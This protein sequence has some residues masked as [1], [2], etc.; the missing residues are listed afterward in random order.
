MHSFYKSNEC[1]PGFYTFRKSRYAA[2]HLSR[3]EPD[4][5]AQLAAVQATKRHP[6]AA[7]HAGRR[8]ATRVEV[9]GRS[10]DSP[11]HTA[12]RTTLASGQVR[13]AKS[14]V[15]T[16]SHQGLALSLGSGGRSG[17]AT[18]PNGTGPGGVGRSDGSKHPSQAATTSQGHGCASALEEFRVEGLLHPHKKHLKG[19]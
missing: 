19:T 13:M 9:C 10:P 4:A 14:T 16:K 18:S 6:R 3:G 2:C 8:G 7:A 17:T 11:F 1:W 5:R 15:T 12:A